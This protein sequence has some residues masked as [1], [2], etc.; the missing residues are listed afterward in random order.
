MTFPMSYLLFTFTHTRAHTHTHGYRHG[1]TLTYSLV[2]GMWAQQLNCM[3]CRYTRHSLDWI[4]C[5][6]SKHYNDDR[7]RIVEFFQVEPFRLNVLKQSSFKVSGF[8][9]FSFNSS[10]R[11]FHLVE[12]LHGCGRMEEMKEWQK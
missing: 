12:S 9:L 8:F 1:H 7:F 5:N 4:S 11:E 2:S 10:Q 6:H 3:E